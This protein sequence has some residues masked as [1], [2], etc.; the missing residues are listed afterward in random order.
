MIGRRVRTMCLAAGVVLAVAAVAPPVDAVC[1][2]SLP[3]HMAQH[4][5][6]TMVAAP[7]IVIGSPI[8]LMLR[9][10]PR[11]AARRMAG[12]HRSR[13][14]RALAAPALAWTLLPAVQIAVYATPL[15]ELA[16]R[17]R[18][19]H[20]A[21]HATLFGAALLFWR[22]LV[23][24]DPPPRPHPALQIGYLLAAMPANDVIGIWL[25]SSGHVEYAAYA[26]SGLAAQRQTGV[27]MLT[28]SFPLGAA[29][30]ATAWSWVQRDHLKTVLR[31]RLP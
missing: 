1:D 13:L 18:P 7:L 10:A 28:G 4:M 31:E 15:F 9:L 14:V 6:L 2:R 17:S 22:P 30:L 21:A 3:A 12:L 23:G 5:L 25:R 19:V 27:I 26:A 8:S 24:V 11:A 20:A 16:D 29:G